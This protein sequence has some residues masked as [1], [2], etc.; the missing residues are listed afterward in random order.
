VSATGE[1]DGLSVG[2]GGAE[3]HNSGVPGPNAV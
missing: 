3:G 1:S 2:R